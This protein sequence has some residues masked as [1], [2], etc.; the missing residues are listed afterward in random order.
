MYRDT[1][2]S[3][4]SGADIS[5]GDNSSRT[6]STAASPLPQTPQTGNGTTTDANDQQ[7]T[8]SQPVRVVELTMMPT[9]SYCA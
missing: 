4:E 2:A 8:A 5:P 3:N 9:G 1:S 7:T 6:V